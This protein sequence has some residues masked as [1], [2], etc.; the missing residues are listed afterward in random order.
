MQPDIPHIQMASLQ[1]GCEDVYL[2]CSVLK[3]A[4]HRIHKKRASPPYAIEY[5]RSGYFSEKKIEDIND[6]KKVFLQYEYG[7]VVE[8]CFS[9][10][11]IFD[12]HGI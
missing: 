12:I 9:E 5:V 1:Y 3:I 4:Y 2:K 11:K 7:G 8:V 6:T 10:Q